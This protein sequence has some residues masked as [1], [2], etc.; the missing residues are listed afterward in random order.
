MANSKS[1]EIYRRA[2]QEAAR[3]DPELTVSQWADQYRYLTERSS[4]EPGRWKTSRVPFLKAIMDDLSPASPVERVVF[5]KG[6]QTG[7]TECGN[8]WIGFV[9]HLA[10]GPMMCVQPSIEMA[11]RNSK[12]RIQPL[13]EDSPVLRDRVQD[14]RERDSGNTLLAKEFPGGILVMTGANSGK[15]LR[16]MSARYLF[17][18][19]VDA[20][21]AEVEK[22]GDPCELAIA[23]THT[24][25]ER[26]KVYIVSTPTIS[27]QSRIE[28]YYDES[29]QRRFWVPCPHCG[30]MQTLEM[31]QLRWPAGQ[32]HKAVYHCVGCGRAIQNHDKT[33]MLAR[34]GWRPERAANAR[35]HGYHINSLYSPVGWLSWGKI[36]EKREAA[37]KDQ[38]LLRVF[39]NTV[40]GLPWAE[41][42]EVPDSDRLY[43]R[44]EDYDIGR[45]PE[46]GLLLTAGVD[47]QVNRIEAE[48]VAWGRDRQSWSIDYRVFE[49]PTNQPAVWQKL[50]ALLDEEFPS[51]AGANVRI[52]RFAIDSGYATTTVYDWIRK[53]N[54]PRI[55][56]VKGESHVSN[57]I[58]R[59]SAVEPSPQGRT[60]KYGIRV[61]PVNT[62][63]AKE[64]LYRWLRLPVPD[65]SR[66]EEW[67][68]GFCHFPMYGKEYFESLTSEH[69]VT[70][71]INGRRFSRFEP[72][73]ERNEALDCRVY[74]RAAALSLRVDGWAKSKWD[75]LEDQ[76]TVSPVVGPAAAPRAT[77]ARPATPVPQFKP[78]RANNDWM[79]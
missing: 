73:R 20:Y 79:D 21:P 3:P 61:W 55:I 49:G 24:F 35:V 15:G 67:A 9:I 8:N 68:P 30:R 64:E 75:D 76:M 5:Q 70:R 44:R 42:G 27:G 6:A 65:F 10:H 51:D 77:V 23:R 39:R 2:A 11:K 71:T 58:G 78:V 17:L 34:G 7:G 41:T 37:G 69:L 52:K 26:A 54:S 38:G 4:A 16:S 60:V 1:A 45:L 32:P 66:G 56:A 36:A 62:F 72:T 22:E 29:D 19:E 18:D 53:M 47:I 50:A 59:A 74:A 31:E 63:I 43:E 12:Q 46:G 28:R 13:I 14:A 48:V 57:L 25:A 40:L 33:F